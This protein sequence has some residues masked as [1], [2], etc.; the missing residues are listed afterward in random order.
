MKVSIVVPA[1]DPDIE[2]VEAEK[3]S[4]AQAQHEIARQY[5][6]AERKRFEAEIWE[7]LEQQGVIR[8]RTVVAMRHRKMGIGVLCEIQFEPPGKFT[9]VFILQHVKLTDAGYEL[10]PSIRSEYS[11]YN[12]SVSILKGELA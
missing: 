11:A 2:M 9:P 5:L 3:F 6:I 12:L 1:I 10:L 8:N 4:F 7:R